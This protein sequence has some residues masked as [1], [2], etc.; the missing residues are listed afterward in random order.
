MSKTEARLRVFAKWLQDSSDYNSSY[1]GHLES[2]VEAKVS[3]A[4]RE[5]GS[6]LEE[7]L[8]LQEEELLR[9]LE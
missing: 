4:T 5:I 7:I 8:N 2:Y 6:M 1:D 3:E 9:G